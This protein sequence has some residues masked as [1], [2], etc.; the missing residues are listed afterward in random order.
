MLA[1]RA[2]HL[3]DFQR[4]YHDLRR[5]MTTV[6][7]ATTALGQL[8]L[9]TKD[10]TTKKS[11]VKRWYTV[12]YL[13]REGAPHPAWRH[14][15][16]TQVYRTREALLDDLVG[17]MTRGPGKSRGAYVAV[18]WPGQ[19]S[20]TEALRGPVQPLLYVYEDGHVQVL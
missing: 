14:A 9:S 13:D 10:L 20:E 6:D 19:L 18:A 2:G 4:L 17:G 15:N 1:K 11:A 3:L 8:G 16:F 7:A 12:A 5:R